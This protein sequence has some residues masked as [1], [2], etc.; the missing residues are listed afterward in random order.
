M[1]ANIYDLRLNIDAFDSGSMTHPL[2]R[3]GSGF[4]YSIHARIR[5]ATAWKP[6]TKISELV[7]KTW[8][9]E[10]D[11]KM[12]QTNLTV[13]VWVHVYLGRIE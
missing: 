11:G 10:T 3:A 4:W 13:Y 12:R 9:E 2:R 5:K 7:R 6:N 8:I 1:S